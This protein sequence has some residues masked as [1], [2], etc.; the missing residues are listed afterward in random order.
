M[1]SNPGGYIPP[2]DVIG[3]DGL[4]RELW[5]T[6]GEQSVI[7]TAERRMGKTSILNKMKDEAP[8]SKLLIYQDLEAVD[9]PLGFV[10]RVYRAVV[11]HLSPHKR[12]SMKARRFIE[13]LA[14]AEVA[15]AVTFPAIAKAHWQD[16]L[17]AAIGDLVEHQEGKSV[18]FLWDEVPWMLQKIARLEGESTAMQVLDTL[19]SLRHTYPTVRMVYTGSLGLHHVLQD[20]DDLGYANSPVNDMMIIA[21]PTLAPDD[22][23][24]LATR[25]LA[26]EKIEPADPSAVA[27]TIAFA[28]DGLP[29]FI[30]HVVK[31]LTRLSGTVDPAA[32]ERVVTE[33]LIDPQ[34]PWRL[35][36]YVKRTKDYY[37]ETE[38]PIALAL[39]DALAPADTALKLDHLLAKL[40]SNRL[41]KDADLVRDVLVLLQRDHYLAQQADGTYRFLYP[42]IARSW[43]L[44]RG[45]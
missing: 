43:R 11:E 45:I 9:S 36:H 6:L 24:D 3:R 35:R 1:K 39:L 14:G 16:I 28:V 37:S 30:H 7:L 33:C 5:A 17:E 25:L 41:G 38:R 26:G 12:V 40:R 13:N 10:E 34:D 23:R 2:D 8:P 31:R 29:F 20:L 21:V 4:I 15:G 42:I 27:D 19:R 18:I 44:Q 22:A 32:I